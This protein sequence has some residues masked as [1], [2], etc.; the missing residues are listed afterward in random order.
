MRKRIKAQKER[1]EAE[2]QREE[3]EK[4]LGREKKEEIETINDYIDA[5][6]LIGSKLL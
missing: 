5:V 3:E 6:F 4:N 1:L 2:K